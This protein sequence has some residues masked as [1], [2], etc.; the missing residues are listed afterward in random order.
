MG[1]CVYI[2]VKDAGRERR[3]MALR[4]RAPVDNLKIVTAFPD[5]KVTMRDAKLRELVPR[6]TPIVLHL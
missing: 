4:T 1:L 2:E 6:G 3:R 5:A